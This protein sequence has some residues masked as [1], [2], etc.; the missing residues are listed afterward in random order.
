MESKSL[1]SKSNT[2]NAEF[3]CKI[4]EIATASVNINLLV[5]NVRKNVAKDQ[6]KKKEECSYEEIFQGQTSVSYY[7]EYCV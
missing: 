3:C 7:R 5:G 2:N 6:S 4:C 1:C